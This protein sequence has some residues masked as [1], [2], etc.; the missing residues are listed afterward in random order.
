MSG[1]GRG[2][3][4]AQEWRCRAART[5]RERRESMSGSS[6][7]RLAG[8]L[9]VLAALALAAPSARAEPPAALPWY[10]VEVIVFARL[11]APDAGSERWPPDPGSP[12]I[13]GAIELLEPLGDDLDPELAQGPLAY[14]ALP[15]SELRL[16]E[17]WNRL[18]RS[19][20]YRPLL[21]LGWVQP[22]VGAG[23]ARPIHVRLPAAGPGAAPSAAPGVPGSAAE[24][25][26]GPA[27]PPP[28][29]LLEGTLRLYRSRYLHL[30]ADLLYR[31]GT[32]PEGVAGR[33]FRLTESRRMRSGRLHYLDHPL[34]G[35]LVEARR[36]VR[37]EPPAPAP[38]PAAAPAPAGDA[39]SEPAPGAP[40][41]VPSPEAA[42]PGASD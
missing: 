2:L 31:P 19:R 16:G 12:P 41:A 14:Q 37:P 18:R 26:A 3:T 23:E 13:E 21:H 22:G 11:E 20:G 17:L 33:V 40:A 34:F 38:E 36:L 27:E 32:P 5:V 15:G 30:E 29:P 7:H 10:A 25:V 24:G 8:S 35:V 9:I 4:V 28:A 1:T 39:A 42:S 6:I